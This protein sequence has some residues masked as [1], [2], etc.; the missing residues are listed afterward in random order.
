MRTPRSIDLEITS[1]CNASCRY[2]YYLNN[3]GVTYQDMST[4]RWLEVFAELSAC[5][6]MNVSLLGGEPLLRKDL[7]PLIDGIVANRMRFDLD[8]QWQ[9]AD[10]RR[11]P[12]ACGDRPL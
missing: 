4:E 8:E 5:Q 12:A 10:R 3:Q 11:C 2:C 7:F 1:G 9:P 6:V